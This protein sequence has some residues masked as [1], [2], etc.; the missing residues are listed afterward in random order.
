L[1]GS[2]VEV[3]ESYHHQYSHYHYHSHFE[4]KEENIG[5]AATSHHHYQNESRQRDSA[6]VRKRKTTREMLEERG[7]EEGRE[8]RGGSC[9][10]DK[11]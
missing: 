8:M 10:E 5:T 1:P 9:E 7:V 11:H 2:C 4:P 6:E 3:N